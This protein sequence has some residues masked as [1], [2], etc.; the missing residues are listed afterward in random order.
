MFL[1]VSRVDTIR[2]GPGDLSR[3]GSDVISDCLEAKYVNRV[4]SG[5]GL[6]LSLAGVDRVCE[7][8]VFPADGGAYTQVF[9]RLLVFRP[10]VGEVLPAKVCGVSAGGIRLSLGFFEDVWV[11]AAFLPPTSYTWRDDGPGGRRGW[12]Y[13][14]PR[15]EVAPPPEADAD[16][17]FP[18]LSPSLPSEIRDVGSPKRGLTS[19]PSFLRFGYW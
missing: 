5:L 4:E 3:P 1:L 7:S 2:I 10:F 11:P 17:S 16:P 8:L 14:P 18:S 6:V 19:M 12:L 13:L 15:G 9:F